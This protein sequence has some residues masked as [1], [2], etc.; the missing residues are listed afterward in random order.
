MTFY[1]TFDYSGLTDPESE[2]EYEHEPDGYAQW[3]RE[4][5]EAAL[6][7]DD[8]DLIGYRVLP[9]NR[10]DRRVSVRFLVNRALVPAEQVDAVQDALFDRG[11]LSGSFQLGRE[12]LYRVTYTVTQDVYALSAEEAAARVP[13]SDA[14]ATLVDTDGGVK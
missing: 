2:R 13:G 3:E 4:L 12:R 9:R 11:W 7:W 5:H 6:A 14:R 1:V 10:K 8:D